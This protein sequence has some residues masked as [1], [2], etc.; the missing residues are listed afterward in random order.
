MP[1]STPGEI[2]LAL[3]RRAGGFV[4]PN[5]WD[6]GSAILLA[7]AGF[8]AIGTTSAGIA[9]S[10]GLQDYGS[11]AALGVSREAMFA[12]MAEIA[13]AVRI[14]V[15]GDLEAGYGDTPEAVAE[16]VRLAID[17][18]LAG[19]NIED[20]VPFEPRLYDEG[21]AVERIAAAR[22]A[23]ESSDAAFVLTARTDALAVS[24]DLDQAI[25]RANLYRQAGADCLFAPG[26]ADLETSGALVRAIEGPVN[27]VVGLAGAAPGA[28]ALLA[29][30]VQRISLGGTIARAAFGF[31][32]KAAQEL[33]EHGTLGFAADQ[34]PA[35]EL[36]RIFAKARSSIEPTP[37][38]L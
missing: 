24:S 2:F 9:F 22:Q 31:L 3:H 25:R 16:T 35:G 27:V 17:A 33:R 5:A 36:N 30:G 15:N 7:D 13:R 11:A 20:K 26:P 1:P 18:G 8:Q 10:M 23:I 38:A 6:A 19:G 28:S 32:R 29:L 37:A 12:R 34:I 21:L 14:P 4:M